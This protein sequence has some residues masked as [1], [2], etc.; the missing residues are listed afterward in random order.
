MGFY[1][2]GDVQPENRYYPVFRTEE[3]EN[4]LVTIESLPEGPDHAKVRLEFVYD[5]MGRRVRKTVLSGHDGSAYQ[6]TNEVTFVYDGWNL[7]AALDE[8]LVA[9]S[10]ST[11]F[12]LWGLDLSGSLQGAGGVG[13]L[14]ATTQ[15]GASYSAC[16]DGNGNVMALVDA[17]DGTLA[18]EYEYGPFG[19][20]LKAHGDGAAENAV[21][22]SSKYMDAESGL[23]YYGY[24]YLDPSTGRWPSRDPIEEDGGPN[25][26]AFVGNDPVRFVD[27]RGLRRLRPEDAD[28]SC[29]T[30]PLIDT[31]K[32]DLEKKFDAARKRFKG[33]GLKPGK[34]RFVD[35]AKSKPILSGSCKDTAQEVLARFD[36][37]P[38]CW[39][40]A[41]ETRHKRNGLG[42]YSDH[43]VVVCTSLP[44]TGGGEKIVFDWWGKFE[45]SI[46]YK[47]FLDEW[48]LPGPTPGRDQGTC[49]I[50]GSRTDSCNGEQCGYDQREIL[51]PPAPAK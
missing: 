27:R 34:I 38:A 47:N 50:E 42:G 7:I 5:Y 31:G 44:E 12:F 18:G 19:E 23:L 35:R 36:P 16:M 37:L 39:G 1:A 41:T 8:D 49:D 48:K 26:Y 17:S 14:L 25:L 45:D 46:P 15:D 43:Q 21:R 40:C 6:Q 33:E 3:S 10:T 30:Q 20:P 13:G 32:A 29:C 2:T 11:N 51:P 28:E 24:R 22:F 4:R 9:G